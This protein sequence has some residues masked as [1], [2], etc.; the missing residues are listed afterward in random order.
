MMALSLLAV[1]LPLGAGD[2]HLPKNVTKDTPCL[3]LIHGGGWTEMNRRDVVGVADYF[4]RDL[5]FAV[6][7]IDCGWRRRSIHG[8]LVART[9]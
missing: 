9:A 1:V 5:G 6:Y 3:L 4:S 2:L 8:R 7:N